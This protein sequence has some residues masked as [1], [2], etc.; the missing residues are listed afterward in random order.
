MA[1][2]GSISQ[3]ELK[4][5]TIIKQYDFYQHLHNFWSHT[6]YLTYNE[7]QSLMLSTHLTITYTLYT[8]NDIASNVTLIVEPSLFINCQTTIL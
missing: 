3:E 7:A 2:G 5:T 4:A 1:I 6:I 8:I